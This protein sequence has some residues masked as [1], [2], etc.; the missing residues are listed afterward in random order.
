MMEIP[1]METDVHLAV[2]LNHVV[3]DSGIRTDLIISHEQRTM[4]N[5]TSE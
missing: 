4:K 1:S 2:K 5:V 3:M